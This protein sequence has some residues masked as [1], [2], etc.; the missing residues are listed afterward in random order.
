M[1]AA[2]KLNGH[3]TVTIGMQHGPINKRRLYNVHNPH[4]LQYSTDTDYVTHMPHPDQIWV[5]DS[6]ARET[7]LESGYPKSAL[8]IYESQRKIKSIAKNKQS[9]RDNNFRI[10]IYP[11]LWDLKPI[12]DFLLEYI[13][14]VN[15][16]VR[17][18]IKPHPR[19]MFNVN[20]INAYIREHTLE[21]VEIINGNMDDAL[22]ITD[23]AIGTISSALEEAA[24]C[25]IP[26]ALISM[27][28]RYNESS[29]FDRDDVTIIQDRKEIEALVEK[30][31]HV[32]EV[33]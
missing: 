11:T 28:E 1:N 7:L 5:E 8:Q 26:V 18:I 15:Q 13:K 6:Q 29:L 30:Y 22:A 10:V 3:D 31:S 12:L 25:N 19:S 9:R 2:I 20:H 32:Y 27:V 33:N 14:D 21:N 16:S 24:S 4:R 23:L 17:I